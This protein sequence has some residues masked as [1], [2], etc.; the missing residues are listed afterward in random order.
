MMRA[1]LITMQA[2]RRRS[3]ALG[4]WGAWWWRESARGALEVWPERGKRSGIGKGLLQSLHMCMHM[5]K[6]MCM[7]LTQARRR[8]YNLRRL[9]YGV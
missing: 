8:M 1:E 7:Q 5:C 3:T 2:G 9:R 4:P 6:Y